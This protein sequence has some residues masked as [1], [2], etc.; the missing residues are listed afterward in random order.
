MA[1]AR[2]LRIEFPGAFYHVFSRGNQKQPIFFSD[3]DRCFFLN[4]MRRAHEKF[5]V[6][7]HVYCL[8]P[9]HF[10]LILE[11]PMGNLSRIMHFL[12]TKYTVYFNKK[13]KRHGH[14]FQGRFR[15]VLIEAVSYA[16]ELSRYIH[17]NP[18]R[19]GLVDHPEQYAWSSFVYYRGTAKPDSW[20]ETSV[21][22]RLFGE[23]LEASRKAYG[24]F[25]IRG[26]GEEAPASIKE[27]VR[28]GIL[29]SEEF[30]AR[31]RKEHLG[32]EYSKP[33]REKPQLRKLRKKPDLS[34]ILSESEKVLGPRNK[35]LVPIA[36]FISHKD[37]ALKLKEIGE[38]F[39]LS[40]SSVSNAC[41]KARAAIAS[42]V[43]L[44]SA[45]EEIEQAVTEAEEGTR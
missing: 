1:L 14:L 8:M 9:N 31:I 11:T 30:I 42:N 17:L 7:V 6:I 44:A 34:Q 36:V 35:Y 37:S 28:K 16:K 3:D 41:S 5:G 40:I 33:D 20:L 38:F 15:S 32:D 13:H 19:S 10:H 4:C 18:V 45:M 21:I 2:Q 26:I 24:E 27:S 12:I 25:V 39:S 23:R 22:L 29:G 43:A